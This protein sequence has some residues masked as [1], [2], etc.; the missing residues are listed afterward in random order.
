MD[1][2]VGEDVTMLLTKMR[3]G[4]KDARARLIALVYPRLKRMAA[5]RMKGERREHTLQPTA[6]VH[7]V[8]IRLAGDT[9]REWGSRV[10]FFAFASELM[11]HILVDAARRHRATKRGGSI[12][13]TE[14]N[15]SLAGVRKDLNVVV[16][17]DR[18]LT[19][20]QA[21][22]ARQAKVVEMRC[23]AGLTEREIALAL[24]VSDRTVKRDWQMALAWMRKELKAQ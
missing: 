13:L 6:L 19:R 16:E 22:D 20:L 9:S 24:G 11:R 18:L 23:F 4:D 15:D 10:H 14:L 8:F 7:E 2:H 12:E 17:V 3:E 1:D 5:Q 21:L